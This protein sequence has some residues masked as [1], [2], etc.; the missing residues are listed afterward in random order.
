MAEC[1]KRCLANF[2]GECAVEK[3][4]GAIERVAHKVTFPSAEVAAKF[5][6]ASREAFD[7]YFGKK[8]VN[9]HA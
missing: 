1:E 9:D 2:N 3:C 7:I 5:Y 6:K 8:E 4:E